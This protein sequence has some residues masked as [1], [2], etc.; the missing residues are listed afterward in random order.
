VSTALTGPA[1]LEEN[2]RSFL[3]SPVRYATI[4]TLNQDGSPHQ[5]VIWYLLRRDDRHGDHI[6]VNSRRGRRWP[7]NLFRDPRANLCVYEAETAVTLECEVV[8]TYEGEEAQADIAAMARRYDSP[9][10]AA[11]EEARFRTEDRV[12]FILRPTRVLPHGDPS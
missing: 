5:I 11:A 3:T 10:D 6:V 4:A 7:T 8:E 1:R 9:E 2:V 12:T